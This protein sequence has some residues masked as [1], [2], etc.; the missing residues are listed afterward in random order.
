[1]RLQ[2]IENLSKTYSGDPHLGQTKLNG[3]LLL[4][5]HG[6]LGGPRA[7]FCQKTEL[8][9]SFSGA[10]CLYEIT[11]PSL[12]GYLSTLWQ[13]LFGQDSGTD[14]GPR[15]KLQRAG[16][17]QGA[18]LGKCS[19]LQEE[20]EEEVEIDHDHDQIAG[21]IQL[22]GRLPGLLLCHVPIHLFCSSAIVTSWARWSNA[23]VSGIVWGPRTMRGAGLSWDQ[24]GA[25]LLIHT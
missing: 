2:P 11:K 7:I 3:L 22:G 6:V 25:E 23:I 15:S 19:C 4:T 5:I 21:Q 20:E 10:P 14:R 17:E 9:S 1:M 18:V 13:C 8:Q 24:R 16:L 12:C